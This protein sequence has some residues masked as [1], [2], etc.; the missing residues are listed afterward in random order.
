M[1]VRKMTM[2]QWQR[3][4]F[5]TLQ[6]DSS[7][8]QAW[9]ILGDLGGPSPG[10]AAIELCISRQR[11][12]QLIDQGKLDA[13]YIIDDPKVRKLQTPHLVMITERSMDR[14]L[15]SKPGEQRQLPLVK[16]R[17]RVRAES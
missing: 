4:C 12:H 7:G 5:A 9:D 1:A 2:R 10:G 6:A 11:V 14:W 15:K 13:I 17:A 8:R 3:E 16:S